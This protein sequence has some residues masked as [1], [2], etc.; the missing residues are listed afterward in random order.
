MME[1]FYGVVDKNRHLWDVSIAAGK[2]TQNE[3]L[4]NSFCSMLNN[5]R[6]DLSPCRV[7]KFKLVEVSDG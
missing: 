7:A 4:A 5:M 3:F 2:L 6:P 1:I